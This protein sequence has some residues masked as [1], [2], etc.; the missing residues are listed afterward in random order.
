MEEECKTSEI[1]EEHSEEDHY[2][3]NY[4]AEETYVVPEDP[5]I[6]ERLEWFRDQKLGFMMHWGPYSQLGIV[7]SWG[8]CDEEFAAC[9]NDWQEDRRE[10]K[11]E[12]FDLNKTFNPVRF[13]PDQWT[14]LMADNGFR[15]ML[16]TTKHHDGFCM[17][18]TRYTDYKVTAPD[19]PFSANKRADICKNLFDSARKHGV[20]VGAY[21]SKADWSCPD[22]WE[23]RLADGT[24]YGRNVSYDVK[25]NPEK[26]EKFCDYTRGQILELMKD[27][28]RIDILWLDAGW[29]C[30]ANGQDIHIEQIIDEAR[31]YQPWLLAADRTVGGPCENYVTPEQMIPPRPM[32]IPWESCITL[33]RSFAYTY[34]D[35]Y[36]SAREVLNILVNV[37]AKGGNLALNVAPQPDG[38]MPEPAIAVLNELGAWLK[39]SGE[40]IYGTRTAAPYQVGNFGFTRKGETV[41]AIMLVDSDDTQIP[42]KI[43]IPY[44]GTVSSVCLTDGGRELAFTADAAGILVDMPARSAGQKAPLAIAFT[45]KP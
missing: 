20:A 30:R 23:D 7:E 10:F 5:L 19:C 34:N 18:D 39:G 24:A 37:V 22:Y 32:Q 29:V 4:S 41:Y 27:Y 33:G 3:H 25:K 9:H 14:K 26:W 13:N 45:M 31:K 36:R 38:R 44:P 6:R 43:R 8:V 16:F 15:Y 28:G 11:R 17:W 12:Y 1:A 21:F 40:A 2:H 35:D 42:A